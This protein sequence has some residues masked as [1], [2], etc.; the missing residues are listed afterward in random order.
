MSKQV[1]WE[2]K[3]SWFMVIHH[4][5]A[6]CTDFYCKSFTSLCLLAPLF[7]WA[8]LS[9]Y[10]DGYEYEASLTLSSWEV[11]KLVWV[12]SCLSSWEVFKLLRWPGLWNPCTCLS[13][14]VFLLAVIYG[15][16]TWH[17]HVCSYRNLEG[18]WPAAEPSAGWSSRVWKRY[19]DFL[20]SGFTVSLGWELW[21]ICSA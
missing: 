5:L 11:F 7:C 6:C 4:V 2:A 12:V 8:C 10:L 17:M 20:P 16:L 21:L 3:L 1:G 14:A 13:P 18:I 15:V 9:I 19:L